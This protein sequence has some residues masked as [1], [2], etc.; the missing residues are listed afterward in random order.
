[1][2]LHINI[3]CFFFIQKKFKFYFILTSRYMK[4]FISIEF[5]YAVNSDQFFLLQL[6]FHILS[7]VAFFPTHSLENKKANI[8]KQKSLNNSKDRQ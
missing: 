8:N 1:M 6:F 2:V 3:A 5:F 4:H 7:T